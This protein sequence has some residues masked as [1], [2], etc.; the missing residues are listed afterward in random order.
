MGLGARLAGASSAE[1]RFCGGPRSSAG[2]TPAR[3]VEFAAR[4]ASAS[5]PSTWTDRMDA[6]V[7]ALRAG[8]SHPQG[9]GA[10]ASVGRAVTI[11]YKLRRAAGAALSE[12][13][14]PFVRY[15]KFD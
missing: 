8:R 6:L 1:R 5:G 7:G 9:R 13:G 2:V 4:P 14:R 3:G 10:G 11:E 15:R 12:R